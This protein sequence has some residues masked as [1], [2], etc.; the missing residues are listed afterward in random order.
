MQAAANGFDSYETQYLTRVA[1]PWKTENRLM[2]HLM[3]IGA[4]GGKKRIQFEN[5]RVKAGVHYQ[6]IIN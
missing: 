4:S 5:V 6:P 3:W 2:R 1:P